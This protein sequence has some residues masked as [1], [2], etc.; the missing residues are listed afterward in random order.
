MKAVDPERQNVWHRLTAWVVNR[1]GG[2]ART[3][4]FHVPLHL[5]AFFV[6]YVATAHILEQEIVST[7]KETWSVQMAAMGDEIYSVAAK[8]NRR[9]EGAAHP[10]FET[11]HSDHRQMRLELLTLDSP[12]LAAEVARLP[13]VSGL[14][15]LLSAEQTTWLETDVTGQELKGLVRI[16]ATHRCVPCHAVGELLA[17]ASMSV[18]VSAPLHR[19]RQQSR[20]N[21]AVLIVVWATAL[22]ISAVVVQRSARRLTTRFEAQLAAAEAGELEPEQEVGLALDPTSA[23][24]QRSLRRFLDR[25]RSRQAEV[26]S[27]LAHTSQLASV[28]ELAAGLAHEI[29]NPLAGIQGVLELMRDDSDEPETVG[30]CDRMLSELRRVNQTLQ[31][32]LSSARPSPPQ[33][34]LIDLRELLEELRRLLEPGLHQRGIELRLEHSAEPLEARVDAGQVRQIL[35]NLISNAGEALEAGGHIWIHADDFQVDCGGVVITVRDD[36]PGIDPAYLEKIFEPFFSTKFTGT[37]LGLSIA[38]SL[39][40]QHGG[41]LHAE[42]AAGEG[43]T[44]VLIV[45]DEPQEEPDRSSDGEQEVQGWP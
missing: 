13:S 16:E 23:N 34:A 4:V 12:E 30:L 22:G 44:F 1:L 45:P 18:D 15:A 14:E 39:A 41:T 6:L 8:P 27:R 9:G 24:L 40:E 43:S 35:T 42:S 19:A 2:R 17:L 25:H 21:L 5:A 10:T 28:G 26:A 36:G 32:M 20:R 3:W 31:A 11:L 38:R 37:G 33:L 7:T 29:K